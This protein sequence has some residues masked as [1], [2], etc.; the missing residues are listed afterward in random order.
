MAPENQAKKRQQISFS[1]WTSLAGISFE[2]QQVW[3]DVWRLL[4]V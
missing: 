4:S 1:L 3:M 2:L